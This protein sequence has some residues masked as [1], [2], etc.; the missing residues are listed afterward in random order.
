MLIFSSSLKTPAPKE[1]P[2]GRTPSPIGRY[3]CSNQYNNPCF[4]LET[5]FVTQGPL[6]DAVDHV[7]RGGSGGWPT[8]HV[9]HRFGLD[10]IERHKASVK[11]YP[12]EDRNSVADAID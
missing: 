6:R 9:G 11:L 2:E 1:P 4:G 5:L 10:G 12:P 7:R 3:N 8:G